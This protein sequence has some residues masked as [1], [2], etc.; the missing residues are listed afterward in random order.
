MKT[1]TILVYAGLGTLGA[2]AACSNSGSSSATAGSGTSSTTTSPSTT[3]STGGT[4]GTTTTAATTTGGGT[5]AVMTRPCD[6][7]DPLSLEADE[8]QVPG[9]RAIYTYGETVSTRCIEAAGANNLCLYGVGADSDDG[10]GNM[11]ANWGAGLGIQ[12][13]DAEEDGT[14]NTPWD[15]TALGITAV[16]FSIAGP[17][18]SAPVRFGLG[19]VNQTFGDGDAAITIPFQDQPH[20]NGIDSENDITADGTYTVEFSNLYL[21]EWTSYLA[22]CNGVSY[23]AF[24]AAMINAMQFQ[25]VT[26]PGVTT[27]YDFCVSNITWL[28]ANGAPVDVPVPV[29]GA[30]GAGGEASM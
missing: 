5:S 13:A 23:C 26:Q 12:L 22:Q 30:G 20:V 19:M 2:M 10:A 29:I 18:D 9:G 24:N 8:A 17:T 1:S 14:V 7:L 4:A 15:A 3:T 21:P 28:D 25:V 11:Y 6:N 27:P 16:Q